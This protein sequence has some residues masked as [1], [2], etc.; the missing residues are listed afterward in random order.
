MQPHRWPHC[1][2]LYPKIQF[3]GVSEIIKLFNYMK[4]FINELM[5]HYLSLLDA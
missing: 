1:W 5:E 4:L 3:I 2:G